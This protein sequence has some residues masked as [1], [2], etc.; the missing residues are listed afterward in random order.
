VSTQRSSWVVAGQ[1]YNTPPGPLE[2]G[3]TRPEKE[4]EKLK[5]F[6]GGEKLL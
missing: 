2:E 3:T 4:R 1:S 5:S 6:Y